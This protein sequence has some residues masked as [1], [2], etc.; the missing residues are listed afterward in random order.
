MVA[1]PTE[2]KTYITAQ[3]VEP[4]QYGGKIVVGKTVD[5]DMVWRE[6]PSDARYHW[7]YLNGQRVVVDGHHTIVAVY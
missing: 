5:G 3:N 4:V 2:V 6:V 1:P 7:A